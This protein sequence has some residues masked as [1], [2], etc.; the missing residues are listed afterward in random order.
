MDSE[1]PLGPGKADGLDCRHGDKLFWWPLHSVVLC[2]VPLYFIAMYDIA[3]CCN[4]LCYVALFC[5]VALHWI[6]LD[7]IALHCVEAFAAA[8]PLH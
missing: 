7:Y 3:L 2:F 1:R 8:K 4:T 5:D 6:A